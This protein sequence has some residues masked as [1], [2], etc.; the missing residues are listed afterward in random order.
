MTKILFLDIDGTLTETISGAD[1]KQHP[2]DVKIIEGA[3]WAIA[4]FHSSG[5]TCIG[6]SNQGGVAKGFKSLEATIQEMQFTLGLI[7]ELEL[8]LFCPDFEGERIISVAKGVY[9]R[10]GSKTSCF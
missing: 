3:Y 5:W 8:I 4:H 9:R 2:E 10:F 1:F 6:V 7:P